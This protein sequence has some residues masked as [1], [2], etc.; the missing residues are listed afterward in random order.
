MASYPIDPPPFSLAV[1]R[2]FGRLKHE[3]ALAR[4]AFA[5]SSVSRSMPT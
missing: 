4:F 3:Y 2:E 1:E 5:A